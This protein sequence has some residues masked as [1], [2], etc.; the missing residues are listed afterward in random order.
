VSPSS[1]GLYHPNF[2]P[3]GIARQG[4]EGETAPAV[5]TAALTLSSGKARDSDQYSEIGVPSGKTVLG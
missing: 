5:G 2:E 3:P 4:R 1:S